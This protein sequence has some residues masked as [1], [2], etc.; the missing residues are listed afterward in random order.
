MDK[1]AAMPDATQWYSDIWLLGESTRGEHW[2]KRTISC[3][4]SS[5]SMIF[6]V[7]AHLYLGFSED[8]LIIHIQVMEQALLALVQHEPDVTAG[9]RLVTEIVNSI[10]AFYDQ[11]FPK[12]GPGIFDKQEKAEQVD[13]EELKAEHEL[14]LEHMEKQLRAA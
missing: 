5:R 8:K 6:R 9:F 12:D 14:K 13:F 2:D 7:F 1:Q 3:K 10:F 11:N 4:H